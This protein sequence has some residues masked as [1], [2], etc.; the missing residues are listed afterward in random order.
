MRRRFRFRLERV[1]EERRRRER[2]QQHELAL[3]ERSL[4]ETRE[5]RHEIAARLAALRL[6]EASAL[7][8]ATCA[9]S[10][11]RLVHDEVAASLTA[12][13]E[14]DAQTVWFREAVDRARQRLEGLA[15]DR[16]ALER[17]RERALEEFLVELR[18]AEAAALDDLRR[19]V[20]T[21]GWG[22]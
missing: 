19:P 2:R 3:L 7:A 21:P 1:L 5:R 17:L 16:F 4:R 8:G 15:R 18:R 13:A 9:V 14:L 6:E 11:L 22:A 12:L 20:L 10:E